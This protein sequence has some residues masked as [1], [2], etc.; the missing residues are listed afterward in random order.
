MYKQLLSYGESFKFSDLYHI[1]EAMRRMGIACTWYEIRNGIDIFTELG[2][3]KRKD[4]QNFAIIKQ[5][6]KTELD[7]SVIYCRAQVKG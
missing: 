2:L 3:I 4:K 5:S 6:G 7:A 1:R